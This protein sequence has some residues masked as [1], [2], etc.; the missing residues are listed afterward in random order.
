[1]KFLIDECLSETLAT[2]AIEA[3]HPE[4]SH[5]VWIGKSGWQDWNLMRL[6]L[7]EDWT[8]VTRN[9]YDFRGPME[10]PGARGLYA[11]AEAHAGLVCLNHDVMLR[12]TQQALFRAVLADI[13]AAPDVVNKCLEAWFDGDELVVRRYDLPPI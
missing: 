13:A 6:I 10:A 3:G 8:F 1:M 11:Q 7:D 5:V 4:S 9:G 12:A 2:I